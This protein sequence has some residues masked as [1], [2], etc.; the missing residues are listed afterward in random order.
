MYDLIGDIHGHAGALKALLRK[1]DYK[2]V[3]GNWQ[4]AGRKV[5][6]VGDYIDRGPAIRETLQIVCNMEQS[7][8]AIAIMGNHEYNALAYAHVLPGGDFLRPHNEKNNKQHAATLRQ[9]DAYPGE[10]QQ[11]LRWFYSLRLFVDLPALRAVHAC[12]DQHHINWLKKRNLYTMTEQLLIDSH[13]ESTMAYTVLNDMLKGKEFNIPA[14]YAWLDKDGH[15]RKSNRWKWWVDPKQF[16]YDH[17]LFN[18]P[19]ALRGKMMEEPVDASI[20]PA[21][22]PP[23]FFGHYW[24]ED[25]YPVIQAANVVCIDYSIAK[26]GKLVAYRWNGEPTIDSRNFVS[27]DY[28]G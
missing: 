28:S 2:E 16:P 5:I 23:V 26:Q 13:N 21:D 11:W 27:V 7:K 12:W 6:F 19:D 8:Q 15:E 10:W 20:Y 14:V 9:F 25:L 3:N 4:H 17:F 18:C 24:M 22:A 1:M